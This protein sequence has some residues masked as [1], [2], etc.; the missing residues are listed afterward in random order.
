MVFG[1]TFGNLRE[2]NTRTSTT[3]PAIASCRHRM[4]SARVSVAVL[5]FW[6]ECIAARVVSPL[7]EYLRAEITQ[8]RSTF[9][10]AAV[11]LSEGLVVQLLLRDN[12]FRGAGW[13]M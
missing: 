5:P 13:V 1:H 3:W 2:A 9:R 12:P 6:M 7:R 10:I 4:S 8:I 11:S